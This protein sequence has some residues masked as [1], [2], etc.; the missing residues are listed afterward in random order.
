M[1][2]ENGYLEVVR[3][4]VDFGVDVNYVLYDDLILLCVV[5]MNGYI[6]IV[7]FLIFSGVFVYDLVLG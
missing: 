7:K 6:S 2:C 3:K 1:V 4:F 5:C